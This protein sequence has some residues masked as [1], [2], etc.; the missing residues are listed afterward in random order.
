MI[1]IIGCLVILWWTRV[2]LATSNIHPLINVRVKD[3][4]DNNHL[5]LL[6]SIIQVYL[7]IATH[8]EEIIQKLQFM[9]NKFDCVSSL[10]FS[11][12]CI[13][14]FYD[15]ILFYLN[16]FYKNKWNILIKN[17]YFFKK[18]EVFLEI[19]KNNSNLI[20]YVFQYIQLI[21]EFDILI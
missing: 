4:I 8:V 6:A 21:L 11:I 12:S 18:I 2:F 5:I 3:F 13:L 20:S 16:L 9:F 19:R 10:S 15:L 7:D 14:Y 1:T 17:N